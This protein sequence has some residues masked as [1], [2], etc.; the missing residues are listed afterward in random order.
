MMKGVNDNSLGKGGRCFGMTTLPP[1]PP[2]T[3]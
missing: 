2:G 3:I 1:Q